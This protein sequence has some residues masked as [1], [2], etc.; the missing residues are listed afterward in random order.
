MKKTILILF[1][2][3]NFSKGYSFNCNSPDLDVTVNECIA[4]NDMYISLGIA[5]SNLPENILNSW[6]SDISDQVCEANNGFITKGIHCDNFQRVT[7]LSLSSSD[8]TGSIP[9]SI[10]NLINLTDLY[11]HKNQIT[12]KIPVEIGDLDNLSLLALSE[13]QLSGSI[14]S[15]I[16]RLSSLNY[17][18]LFDNRLTG[19]IPPEIGNIPF[20]LDLE[21]NNNSITGIIP[22]EIGNLTFVS[23][24]NISNNLI[25]GMI[26]PEIDNLVN[27]GAL[28]MQ[29][30]YIFGEFPDIR[31]TPIEHYGGLSFNNNCISPNQNQEVNN[32][33][34]LRVNEGMGFNA[35][36]PHFKECS[37]FYNGYDL[38]F[39]DSFD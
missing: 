7:K 39:I 2:I 28:N 24:I 27:L 35:Q 1:L 30:N 18:Y 26:P 20:L 34:N 14:P 38:I 17:L 12:G 16:G 25:T 11:L 21:L 33:V 31:S 37:E 23:D 15:E 9:S 13:N 36:R 5:E 29:N 6:G 32:W 19:Y 4:I 8:L 22:P 10:G 3:A